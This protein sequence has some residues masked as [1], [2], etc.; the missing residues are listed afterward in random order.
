MGI[1]ALVGLIAGLLVP[2][3]ALT[4]RLI[5]RP[6]PLERCVGAVVLGLAV[7]P[8]L[9]FASMW[10]L[11]RPLDAWLVLAVSAAVTTACRP[12]RLPAVAPADPREAAMCA[13]LALSAALL[14][15][16]TEIRATY[17]LELFEPC[18]HQTALYMH[19]PDAAGWTLVDPS[20]GDP[21]THVFAHPTRDG[22]GL[23]TMLDY[24][25]PVNGAV[26]AATASFVGTAAVEVLAWLVFFGVAGGAAL[27]ARAVTPQPLLYTLSGAAAL[28]GL[29]GLVA[30]MANETTFALAAGLLALGLACRAERST[31]LWATVGGLCGFAFG[32]RLTALLWLL[33]LGLLAG[34]EARR[35]RSLVALLGGAA[36]LALPWIATYWALTGDVFFYPTPPGSEI[37][38]TL[39]GATVDMRPLNWPFHDT[40]IRHPDHAL[41]PL[42]LLP[43]LGLR[44]MGGLLSVAA[45]GG[46]VLLVRR[47]RLL[48]VSLVWALPATLPLLALAYLDYEKASWILL[49]APPLPL[50]LGAAAGWLAQ[51]RQRAGRV[52]GWAVAGALLALLPGALAGVVVPEDRREYR[53]V[54]PDIE[55]TPR[56]EAER[57]ERLGAWS[58]LPALQEVEHPSRLAA[59]LWAVG[60]G[61]GFRSGAIVVWQ[62]HEDP[63]EVAFDVLLSPTPPRLPPVWEV[64][65]FDRAEVHEGTF[66]LALA[67][68]TTAEARVVITERSHHF[69]VRVQHLDGPRELRYL[70]FVVKDYQS[71]RFAGLVVTDG[72]RD[73]PMRLMGWRID[74]ALDLKLAANYE[75]LDEAPASRT[76]HFG[77]ERR[78][79]EWWSRPAAE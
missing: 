43:V 25:R 60:Q 51:P 12:W 78:T 71:E 39:F 27:V 68:E 11:D 37:T 65:P 41:P 72:E 50:A 70:A 42:L 57:R 32:V 5:D 28:L 66:V 45:L 21:L 58:P 29:H 31:A 59:N 38:Q 64:E 73:L 15:P 54:H 67:L 2:G 56:A 14:L 75:V 18:L 36:L 69:L 46:L 26:F 34:L 33:P 62:A 61:E 3:W 44:S 79:Y 13:A 48:A 9:C 77:P 10:A 6:T 74:G 22:F 30:Y 4:R 47:P 16:F 49:A 8:T 55:P 1:L 20:T 40:L 35:G 17:G 53:R 23:R 52:A 24:Q 19:Q 7:V 63:L 76:V